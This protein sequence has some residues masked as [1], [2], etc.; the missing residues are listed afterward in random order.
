[1]LDPRV[2][3]TGQILLATVPTTGLTPR[4]LRQRAR[5]LDISPDAFDAAL[6]SLRRGDHPLL[7][8]FWGRFYR[9]EHAPRLQAVDEAEEQHAAAKIHGSAGG[10]RSRERVLRVCDTEGRWRCTR[11]HA[12]RPADDYRVMADGTQRGECRT[13]ERAA[14]SVRERARRRRG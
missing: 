4:Q 11:C 12:F 8:L 9:A 10:K 5:T 14:N 6:R 13:C 3:T 7:V 1:M 2:V